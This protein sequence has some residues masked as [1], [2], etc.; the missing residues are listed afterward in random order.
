[1]AKRSK[2]PNK[3]EPVWAKT[4]SEMALILNLTP[5]GMH[6]W[7]SKKLFPARTPKGYN[8]KKCTAFYKAAKARQKEEWAGNSGEIS[9]LKEEQLK[10]R[11]LYLD[12]KIA[13][14]RDEL[15]NV[16]D[17]LAEISLHARLVSDGLKGF[18]NDA[19]VVSPEFGKLAEKHVKK[20]LRKLQRAVK[21][22]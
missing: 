8:V 16:K 12:E 6:R 1:M 10:L 7:T 21:K 2:Q 20:I 13:K 5:Q 4:A 18:E 11:N 14:Q 19:R 15:I 17:H 3:K 9:K 22:A